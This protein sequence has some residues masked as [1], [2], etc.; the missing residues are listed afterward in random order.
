MNQTT[1]SL[2]L[3]LV[4]LSIGS[5]VMPIIFGSVLWKMQGTFLTRDK[6]DD[7]VKLS[8]EQRQNDRERLSRI[9]SKID[10]LHRNR[11]A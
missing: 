8:Q 3:V 10:D 1:D 2:H 6:H 4:I 11:N 9:E 7:F 5:A